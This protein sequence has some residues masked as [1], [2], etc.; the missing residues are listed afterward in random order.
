MV[1]LAFFPY[2]FCFFHLVSYRADKDIAEL[3]NQ[4][5]PHSWKDRNNCKATVEGD[6]VEFESLKGYCALFY[7]LVVEAGEG[8]AP[9]GKCVQLTVKIIF[10]HRFI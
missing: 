1:C 5:I 4:L 6:V 8:R 3:I 2:K 9:Q 7:F 10:L